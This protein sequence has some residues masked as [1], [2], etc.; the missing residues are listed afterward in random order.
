MASYSNHGFALAG[1]VMERAARQRLA[2]LAEE[3]VFAPLGMHDSTF[4]PPP[5]RE[6]ATRH[7]TGYMWRDGLVPVPE[8]FYNDWPAS[9]AVSTA[10]D[11]AALL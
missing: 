5:A 1:L 10:A 11:M 8:I 3:H 7:V 6:D 4:D 9:G 2:D